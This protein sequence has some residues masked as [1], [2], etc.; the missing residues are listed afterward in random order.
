MNIDMT[1]GPILS[2][3]LKFTI[4]ILLGNLFQQFYTVCDTVIVGRTLGANSLAAVGATGTISFLILGFATGTASGFSIVT[5]QKFGG[6][7]SKGVKA[8]FTNGIIIMA[9]IGTVM[10]VA[11]IAG[12]PKILTIMNTPE[13]IYEDAYNYIVVICAGLLATVAYN[14]FAAD[15]RAIG[16]SKVPLYFLIF[17]S[18]LNIGLDFLFILSFH[19]GCAGAAAATVASQLISAVLSWIYIM[20]KEETL[21]PSW[22]D[23]KPNE[24]IIKAELFV[25]LPMGLQYA[26]TASGTMVMQAAMNIFQ[27]LAVAA[28][29]AAGKVTGIYT[30][31][32]MSFG[33]SIATY[34]GQNYGKQDMERIRKGLKLSVII[35]CIYAVAAGVVLVLFLPAELGLFFSVQDDMSVLLPYA[36]VY[37]Y[38]AAAFFVPLGLIFVFRNAMQGCNHS[39]L[40]M[41]AGIVELVTRV[42][43]AFIAIHTHTF[44]LA[45]FCDPAAWLTAGIYCT[46]A[47]YASAKV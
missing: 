9:V 4:P 33:Q 12:M 38:Q 43:C 6:R 5:S 40:A 32:F 14:L 20:K 47:F 16:N 35:S 44:W 25:G 39:I 13:N 15:L 22:S 24:G 37:V 30:S 27:S 2:T 1:K 29:T 8:S 46:V 10:T 19:W 17:S 21:R 36:Q 41:L 34:T 31:V 7:D 3:L 11:C 26:I 18:V 28:N 23:W 45:C 42:V